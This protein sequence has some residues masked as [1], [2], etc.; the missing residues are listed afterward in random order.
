MRASSS[1]TDARVWGTGAGHASTAGGAGARAG[2]RARSSLA[3]SSQTCCAPPSV[4]AGGPSRGGASSSAAHEAGSWGGCEASGGESG[5]PLRTP[6]TARCEVM[7]RNS[8]CSLSR[9]PCRLP[10]G[11]GCRVGCTASARRRGAGEARGACG[12][13]YAAAAA[14]AAAAQRGSAGAAGGR[15]SRLRPVRRR[16][17]RAG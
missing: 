12:E 17:E 8:D 2:R 16:G 14:A 6:L 15:G 7:R 13:E 11:A 3:S 10:R 4:A 5:V 1:A 9:W